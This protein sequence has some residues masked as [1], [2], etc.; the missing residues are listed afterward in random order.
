MRTAACPSF[1][2]SAS[3]RTSKQF[4]AGE[5]ATSI[6]V[7]LYRLPAVLL[8]TQAADIETLARLWQ[9]E[10]LLL[11]LA[12]YLDTLGYSADPSSLRD[13]PLQSRACWS[14]WRGRSSSMLANRGQDSISW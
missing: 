5:V 6:G 1:S 8:P 11:P 4:V 3:T 12:L 13:H 7:Q 2:C 10:S 14:V 9:R